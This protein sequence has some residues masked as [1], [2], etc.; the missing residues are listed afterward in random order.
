M[1]PLSRFRDPAPSRLRYRM[2][3][4]MLTPAFRLFLRAGLPLGCIVLAVSIYLADEDRREALI[5]GAADMRRQIEQRPEFQVRLM[6]IDG[7]SGPVAEELR[8][9]LPVDFPISSFDLDLDAIR[10]K[11]EELDAVAH[12]AARVRSGGV[13][14]L[15]VV[16]RVPAVVWR[17]RA[18]LQLLD[19]E[20]ARV[21]YLQHRTER[22]DLPL[23]A[24]DGA[25][26]AVPEALELLKAAEPIAPRV[27]GILR[28]GERRWDLVLE[29]DQRILL[30]ETQPVAA[31]ERV[32]A[33]NDVQDLLARDVTVIDMR[34]GRRPTV[35]M[36]A[37]AAQAL[38]EAS[39]TEQG[40]N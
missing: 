18:D 14:Q 10:L 3:R 15:D 32:L 33:M 12:A 1:R 30:P 19:A 26:G 31:L 17:G 16:E 5:E 20:G 8:E 29:R 39:R 28:V 9:I 2:E 11:A 40:A 7:A 37:D 35:R 38:R 36:S 13:L 6:A 22:P 24:G 21:A 34:N 27:R 4:L 25:N 23:L